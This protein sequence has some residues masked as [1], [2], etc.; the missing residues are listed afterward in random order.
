MRIAT[1]VIALLAAI[2]AALQAFLAFGERAD[3]HKAEDQYTSF[4]KETVL[5]GTN[6]RAQGQ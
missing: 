6:G 2:F 5:R 3:K 4:L 1:G